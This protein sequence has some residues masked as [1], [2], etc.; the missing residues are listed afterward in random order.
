MSTSLVLSVPIGRTERSE[1][2]VWTRA[3]LLPFLMSLTYRTQTL[4]L[5]GNAG[6]CLHWENERKGVQQNKI[7]PS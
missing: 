2:T 7:T 6:Y 1:V 4:L 5:K 3:I